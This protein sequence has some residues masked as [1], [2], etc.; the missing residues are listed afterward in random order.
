MCC[1]LCLGSGLSAFY[2]KVGCP[3]VLFAPSDFP[4]TFRPR[5]RL[6]GGRILGPAVPPPT[7]GGGGSRLLAVV[8][9]SQVLI[10]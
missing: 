4:S 9:M 10:D 2:D 1:K 3:F 5:T 7:L 6:S 8:A